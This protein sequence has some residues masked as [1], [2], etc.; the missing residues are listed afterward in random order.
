MRISDWS[1]DV[2]SSD[3]RD[4]IQEYLDSALSKKTTADWL[5]TFAG[6]V[7]AAPILDVEQALENPFVVESGKIQTLRHPEHGDFRMLNGPFGFGEPTPANPAPELGAD[8]DA[9]LRE[10]GYGDDRI[11]A[12]RERKVV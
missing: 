12:L 7:P 5:A 2:C 8:T 10:L 4:L 3:L 11:A 6:K 1:S 9:L